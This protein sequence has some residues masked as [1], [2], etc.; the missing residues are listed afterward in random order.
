MNIGHDDYDRDRGAQAF[1]VAHPEL[2]AAMDEAGR[3]VLGGESA[4]E[5]ARFT[6]IGA[7]FVS[8]LFV[9][10][11]A[12]RMWWGWGSWALVA[13]GVTGVLAVS[14]AVEL[15]NALHAV[16]AIRRGGRR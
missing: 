5:V 1:A 4:D 6:A 9:V 16:A 3:R 12:G 11:L 14:A 2:A 15:A 8:V 13:L 10:L 7:A